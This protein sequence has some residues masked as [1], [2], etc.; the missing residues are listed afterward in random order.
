MNVIFLIRR[1]LIGRQTLKQLASKLSKSCSKSGGLVFFDTLFFPSRK[2]RALKTLNSLIGGKFEAGLYF[3]FSFFPCLGTV[4]RY[5]PRTEPA[6]DAWILA[7]LRNLGS[8]ASERQLWQL[9]RKQGSAQLCSGLS[10][11]ILVVD[12]SVLLYPGCP[13]DGFSFPWT[14]VRVIRQ[15]PACWEK[16]LQK[17]PI[18]QPL[19]LK[20]SH[21]PS[22]CHLQ[23]HT[24]HLRPPGLPLPR[25]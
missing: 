23:L 17:V 21:W 12:L 25:L 9:P 7:D 19:S 8:F 22:G 4:S 5:E 3:W 6:A 20:P 11:P 24:T 1:G 14:R 18:H 2:L 13:T 15:A 16:V 10:T